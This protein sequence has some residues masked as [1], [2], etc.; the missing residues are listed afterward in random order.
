MSTNALSMLTRLRQLALH[1]GLIPSDYVDQLR[2]MDEDNDSVMP[3]TPEEKARLQ[4]LLLQAIEDSEECPVCF[5]V[6]DDPRITA[7]S[8]RF[9][10]PW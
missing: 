1:P 6:L 5:G 8:H 9:C 3:V 2:H 4:S 7:C 10:F